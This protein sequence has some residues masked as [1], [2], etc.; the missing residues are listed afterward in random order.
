MSAQA[1]KCMELVKCG[2][3]SLD[4]E[5]GDDVIMHPSF[6]VRGEANGQSYYMAI[7]IYVTPE[8]DTIPVIQ[9]YCDAIESAAGL[10][11]GKRY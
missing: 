6:S 2:Y 8:G 4:G 10:K 11:V 3:T 7:L 1:R 5:S 9:H